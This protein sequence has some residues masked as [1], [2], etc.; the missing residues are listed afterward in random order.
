MLAK[1]RTAKEILTI[2][3]TVLDGIKI[4]IY[5]LDEW[6]FR[7]NTIRKCKRRCN[8]LSI[9]PFV[10]LMKYIIA[11]TFLLAI[12]APLYHLIPLP[13]IEKSYFH[14]VNVLFSFSVSLEV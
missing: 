2:L 1:C 13:I 12:E 10:L 8:S 14:T 6:I 11:D 9:R 3:S 5:S 7:I 4:Y